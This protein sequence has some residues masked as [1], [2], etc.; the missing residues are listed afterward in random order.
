MMQIDN[1]IQLYEI[2]EQIISGPTFIFPDDL[3]DRCTELFR[4]VWKLEGKPLGGIPFAKD[5]FFQRNE[6]TLTD[7]NTYLKAVEHVIYKNT[8]RYLASAAESLAKGHFDRGV[9]RLQSLAR[10]DKPLNEILIKKWPDGVNESHREALQDLAEYNF[11]E[12]SLKKWEA[13]Q[14]EGEERSYIAQFIRTAILTKS[15]LSDLNA[16]CAN[17]RT[18]P[19]I[20]NA[21]SLRH[22]KRIHLNHNH[23][24]KLPKSFHYLVNLEELRLNNNRFKIFPEAVLELPA[25]RELGLSNN[26]LTYLT[27]NLDRLTS[28]ESLFLRGNKLRLIADNFSFPGTLKALT[29]NL[30]HFYRFPPALQRLTSLPYLQMHGAPKYP[31]FRLEGITPFF[32]IYLELYSFFKLLHVEQSRI[33]SQIALEIASLPEEKR[34]PFLE[35]AKLL[36]P[37]YPGDP[38]AVTKALSQKTEEERAHLCTVARHFP[39][40]QE[41]QIVLQK[42][43]NLTDL[44]EAPFSLTHF[45]APIPEAYHPAIYQMILKIDDR[46]ILDF[47]QTL[48][49]L[50]LTEE[51]LPEF[52]R[53]LTECFDRLE[54]KNEASSIM[55]NLKKIPPEYRH[56]LDR[57]FLSEE[58]SE[59]SLYLNQLTTLQD[60][61]IFPFLVTFPNGKTIL[62]LIETLLEFPSSHQ[63]Q[64]FDTL[65]TSYAL[66]PTPPNETVPQFIFFILTRNHPLTNILHNHYQSIL[67]N[68]PHPGIAHKKAFFIIENHLLL[69][70]PEDSLLVQTA[71]YINV[72]SQDLLPVPKNP[73]LLFQ[74]LLRSA[75]EKVTTPPLIRYDETP[76]TFHLQEVFQDFKATIPSQEVLLMLKGKVL[77]GQHLIDLANTLEARL[78]TLPRTRLEETPPFYR[79]EEGEVVHS[80]E[81]LCENLRSHFFTN[82]LDLPYE[83]ELPFDKAILCSILQQVLDAS[84]LVPEGELLSPQEDRLLS[85]SNSIY[86][87][88]IGKREGLRLFYQWLDPCYLYSSLEPPPANFKLNVQKFILGTLRSYMMNFLSNDT[89]MLRAMVGI[90]TAIAQLAHQ[91]TYVKNK[92]GPHLGIK[93]PIQFD[94]HSHT[95]YD[96]LISHPL[97]EL[98]K[99]FYEHVDIKELI[100]FIQTKYKALDG[101]LKNPLFNAMR[102]T[103]KPVLKPGDAFDETD[104]SPKETALFQLL[105]IFKIIKPIP[106]K[107]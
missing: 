90:D 75:K 24:K 39:L 19:N 10:A 106:N 64:A 59:V 21:P 97:D 11:I 105:L 58:H 4:H 28:L 86:N 107:I 69:L 87:C 103:L 88:S 40:Q 80:P 70:A 46:H 42:I 83:G 104:F 35:Q 23:L 82:L 92:I 78:A 68:T 49:E 47:T 30:D 5:A 95:L 62:T 71:A 102:K 15:P 33:C 65:H 61:R 60:E 8:I 14:V 43:A 50:H 67:E 2:R 79:D 85:M 37:C 96:S 34:A 76:F 52:W 66:L 41:A 13:K 93:D 29:L 38:V 56:L 9:S 26:R 91:A 73:Y 17:L 77:T 36:I 20:F 3:A 98:L 81:T 99:I 7:P 63:A 51:E 45:L 31:Q 57:I 94:L 16:T 44:L 32:T 55:K 89:P 74:H 1:L 53:H 22:I 100:V 72:T 27:K 101:K 25:L 12:L 6:C 48:H 18:L 54:N 84:P